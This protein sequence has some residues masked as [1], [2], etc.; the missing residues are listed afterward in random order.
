MTVA[1]SKLACGQ[2]F[3]IA[4]NCEKST[5]DLIDILALELNVK[6]KFITYQENFG[7]F[8]FVALEKNLYHQLS[9]ILL[10][11]DRFESLRGRK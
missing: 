11:T 8:Y 4:D 10:S 5:K 9:V 3:N 6:P 2:I 1:H 7:S